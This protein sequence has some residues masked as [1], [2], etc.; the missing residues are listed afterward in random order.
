[1]VLCISIH[2]SFTWSL[3]PSP[4]AVVAFLAAVRRGAAA[5][6]IIHTRSFI[7]LFIGRFFAGASGLAVGNLAFS[8]CVGDEF[9]QGAIHNGPSD[10]RGVAMATRSLLSGSGS[11]IRME[12]PS[13]THKHTHLHAR[14]YNNIYS[15]LICYKYPAPPQQ[16]RF[17]E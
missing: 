16:I 17:Y 13:H 14:F 4:S 3:F 5:L 2:T 10:S 8:G 6:G 9:A 12:M 1:M 7:Y 11:T 15:R